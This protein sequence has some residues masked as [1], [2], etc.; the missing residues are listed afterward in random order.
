MAIM[1]KGTPEAIAERRPPS[2]KK[3]SLGEGFA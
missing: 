1:G 3:S 2:R